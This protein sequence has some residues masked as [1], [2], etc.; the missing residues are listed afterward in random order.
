MSSHNDD[1]KET[2]IVEEDTAPE[3]TPENISEEVPE[4]TSEEVFK[5]TSENDSEAT[6]ESNN[7]EEESKKGFFPQDNVD[8]YVYARYRR[9][10]SSGHHHHSS[11]HHYGKDHSASEK[12]V[13]STSTTHY[14]DKKGQRKKNKKQR[15]WWKKLLIV[16]AWI[17]GVILSL[18]LCLVIVVSTSCHCGL[19]TLTNYEYMDM[20][21][22][23]IDSA[24]IQV[25]DHGKT[26]TYNDVDYTFNSDVTSILCMGVD[27][28]SLDD[29]ETLNG[30]DGGQADALYMIAID[31]STGKTKVIA[32]PRDIVTDIGVY[33]ERGEYLGTEKHQICLA[34]AYGDGRKTSCT[35]TV[36]AVS[37]LFYQLP[38]NTYFAFDIQA[39]AD[40]NDAVGGVTVTMT[41]NSFYD[42]NHV[43]HFKGETL[44]LYG[45]NA[46]KYVQQREVSQLESTTDRMGRQIN[47]LEAFTSKSIAMTKQDLSTPIDLY[48]IVSNRSESNL[49]A[50]TI[51]A[52]ASCIVTN[53]VSNVEFQKVPGELTSNGT[54]AE[55]VVD[56]AALYELILDIYYTP[57][58]Q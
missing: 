55:Y 6:S 47:Y 3:S 23:V 45:D 40:L 20:S 21:A 34:Y 42:I 10:H 22:P 16:L 2:N 9:S 25:K 5:N 58:E 4:N 38:I 32:I 19:K 29:K 57:V 31:T 48:N 13:A 24:N 44:T 56:E 46:R 37:R 8:D 33:S 14:R 49:T 35:N 54:Y 15:P 30:A 51:T 28:D 7:A 52:F 17:F 26:V 50:S 1:I 12:V 39:I 18:L 36:T 43:Q 41:D 53:G 27:K 11:H